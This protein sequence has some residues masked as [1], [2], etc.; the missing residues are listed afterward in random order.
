[1]AQECVRW[2]PS[3]SGPGAVADPGSLTFATHRLSLRAVLLCGAARR[4]NGSPRKRDAWNQRCRPIRLSH[5]DMDVRIHRARLRWHQSAD[6]SVLRLSV[7]KGT[8]LLAYAL[9]FGWFRERAMR[10]SRYNTPAMQFFKAARTATQKSRRV[11]LVSVVTKL[12]A[13]FGS[14]WRSRRAAPVRVSA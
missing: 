9:P 13:G 4:R 7:I 10:K 11:G 5:K 6:F 14:R 12:L 8:R 3:C 1:M 2:I